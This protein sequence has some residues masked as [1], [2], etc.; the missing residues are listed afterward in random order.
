MG[1]LETLSAALAESRRSGV[2]FPQAWPQ[3]LEAALSG[4]DERDQWTKALLATQ[5]AWEAAYDGKPATRPERALGLVGSDPERDVPLPPGSRICRRCGEPIP[6]AKA[7]NAVYCSR[8]CQR[9]VHGR[10]AA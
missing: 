8:E 10:I 7:S 6:P 1:P 9:G 3:A 2:A 5:S 4:A